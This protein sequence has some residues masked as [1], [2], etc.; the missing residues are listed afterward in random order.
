VHQADRYNLLIR[1]L[2]QRASR[3]YV[4]FIF[5]S[6]CEVF[7]S[8]KDQ[9]FT[10][11]RIK[12]AQ[13]FEVR[14][15]ASPPLV[16]YPM[17]AC[18][19][20]RGRLY[21]AESDGRNLTTRQAIEREL[22]RFVRRLVD[23]DGDGVFD[24]S[25]IFADRMTMPEGGVW[26]DGALYI[27]SAPYL[28]RLEDVDDDGVADK[29]EKILGSMEFDGRANQHGPYLGPN[30]RFYFSGGHFGYNLVGT[31]GSRS[32]Y[33]RAAGIFSCWP[34][35]SD[36]RVEGQGGVNPVDIVF[37]ANGDMLSTC[38]IF[39]SFGGKRHD[40]LVH[41]MWGGLTQRVYGSPLLPETGLR[42]PAVSRWG[43]VA[44]AGL[45]RYRG[46]S[47]GKSYRDTLFAC[48]FNT[49]KVVHVRLEPRDGSFVTVENDFISSESVGFHPA[50]IL[51]DADGS[52]LLLD[53]GG[54]LSWGCPF[55]KNAKPE[56]KG[57]IYRILKK[58]SPVQKDPRG[59]AIDWNSLKPKEL[60]WLLKDSREA[61]RDRAANSLI[62]EGE[63]VLGEVESIYSSTAD[64]SLRKRCLWVVSRVRGERALELLRKALADSD[65]GVR[66][67]AARSLGRLKD[68][69][70]VGGLVGLLDD[71]SPFVQAS[72]ATAIGQLNGKAAIPSLFEKLV[73]QDSLHTR[74]AFVY[75]LIEIG[76]SSGVSAYLSD[77]KYP[78]RQQIA[79]RVLEALDA[80]MEA[81]KIVPLL[82]SPDINVRQEARRV[83]S[84]RKQLK[85]EI[86]QIFRELVTEG[87]VNTANEQL[88]EE[89]VIANAQDVAFQPILL[90]V[91]TSGGAKPEVQSQVMAAMCFL[92]SLPKSLRECVLLGL[93]SGILEVR[94]EALNIAQRF[95]MSQPILTT[96]LL[97]AENEDEPAATR[98]SAIQVLVNHN[99]TLS[100]ALF[101]FLDNLVTNEKI[102]IL[103]GRQAAQV[104]GS[105]RLNLMKESQ[106][107][108]LIQTVAEAR[109]FHLPSLARPFTF[110]GG[111]N[112]TKE[113]IVGDVAWNLLG[114]KLAAA[115]K[116]KSGLSL[117]P[118]GQREE[119]I[120]T[121]AT[122][123]NGDHVAL[124][125]VLRKKSSERNKEQESVIVSLMDG[126]GSGNASRGRVLFHDQRISCGA[127]HRIQGQGGQFGPNLT[128][129]GGIR[130]PRD[131]IEAVLYPSATVVNGFEHYVLEMVDG[132]S[133]GGI[134]QRETKDA[135]YLKNANMRNVRV[136]RSQIQRVKTS[137]VSVMP[138]GLDQLLSREELLDLIAFLQTCR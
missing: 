73:A 21:I 82:R 60:V 127:C 28:W 108:K 63:V 26:H 128:K 106:L 129:I 107:D 38:A 3:L 91:L 54:W 32:G 67:V 37:T 81:S 5:F 17:M 134:I 123:N 48:Q 78:H 122:D 132:K 135:I 131:L 19:D 39:D 119:M 13:G 104:I 42:L 76:D 53:T 18:L 10:L 112:E 114:N 55:S 103:L 87:E 136:S 50:D 133:H 116:K 100:D 16:G 113:T 61:V 137:R 11:P 90:K 1:I 74:H 31:D 126:L 121:F 111:T 36:V 125:E 8:L 23:L 99:G 96:V 29:R 64:A 33:S 101:A 83:I 57:A 124:S 130:Q 66:Q 49:H 71:P 56:I 40:A 46:Q 12:V 22:P 34:D 77:Y 93:N 59:M 47:F 14:L 25:T 69:S 102:P 70:A 86:F 58:G 45:V 68:E 51:E 118:V 9:S 35:G 72:A 120:N 4:C 94:E 110:G 92:D 24:K 115:L 27:I 7:G 20:D 88:I 6:L 44:P 2:F 15:A 89:I 30:G 138:A 79:L 84:S 43:Q 109:S 65:H 105:M 62:K 85:E 75:A 41:W 95:E 80:D 98:T 117:L 97:L 52:L